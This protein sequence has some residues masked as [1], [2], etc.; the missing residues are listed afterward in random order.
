MALTPDRHDCE[1]QQHPGDEG[2]V[3]SMKLERSVF[4]G[5]A[6]GLVS[7]F[8]ALTVLSL[9]YYR[10]MLAF[11]E[12]WW[13]PDFLPLLTSLLVGYAILCATFRRHVVLVS[14]VYL[15]VMFV[16]LNL[17]GLGLS[18]AIFHDGP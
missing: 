14:V 6:L 17:F 9:I 1:D 15:P 12:A 8:I 10:L 3:R 7:P 16:L 5:V 13:M 2:V 11:P 4:G 18:V